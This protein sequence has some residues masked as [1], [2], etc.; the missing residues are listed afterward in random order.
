MT[1]ERN[2]RSVA[3]A[4]NATSGVEIGNAV[5]KGS[6]ND[7]VDWWRELFSKLA[8]RSMKRSFS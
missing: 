5:I 2:G 7:G 4:A 6:S 8:K 1:A 3:S